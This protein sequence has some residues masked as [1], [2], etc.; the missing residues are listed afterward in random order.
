[1]ATPYISID[2]SKKASSRITRLYPSRY[3]N[4]LTGSHRSHSATFFDLLVL[5]DNGIDSPVYVNLAFH[6]RQDSKDGGRRRY[7]DGGL[8]NSV[9]HAIV[10]EPYSQRDDGKYRR[11]RQTPV[12]YSIPP[13]HSHRHSANLDCLSQTIALVETVSQSVLRV[14]AENGRRFFFELRFQNY[15][16][17]FRR[18]VRA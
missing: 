15:A 1:H 8:G 9:R 14:V 5:L 3:R 10:E 17:G 4:R 13:R 2:L 7:Q 6:S 11:R 12:A 18:P 16:A